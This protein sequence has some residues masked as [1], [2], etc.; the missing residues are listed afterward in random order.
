MFT[1]PSS[2]V[3][4]HHGRNAGVF[5]C[6]FGQIGLCSSAIGCQE[7]QLVVAHGAI[8]L[9]GCGARNNSRLADQGLGVRR[10]NEVAY[11]LVTSKEAVRP[12]AESMSKRT[13]KQT[14]KQTNKRKLDRRV[15]TVVESARIAQR[16]FNH[17]AVLFLLTELDAAITFCKLCRLALVSS[18]DF[19]KIDSEARHI[20]FAL[21]CAMQAQDRVKLGPHDRR[22]LRGKLRQLEAFVTLL[23]ER[24]PS[25]R[26]KSIEKCLEGIRTWNGV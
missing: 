5:E 21:G 9:P 22:Q 1:H 17:A 10:R 3:G 13:N 11:G 7:N 16:D 19:A 23:S 26:M 15:S 2:R 14:N 25:P 24:V 8:L 4:L 20:E 12:R 6:A 18:S